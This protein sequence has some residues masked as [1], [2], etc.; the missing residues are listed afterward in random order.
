MPASGRHA[1]CDIIDVQVGTRRRERHHAHERVP[2]DFQLVF[3]DRVA[4]DR[5]FEFLGGADD[6]VACRDVAALPLRH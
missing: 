2:E 1:V 5:G 6:D 3:Q 4:A